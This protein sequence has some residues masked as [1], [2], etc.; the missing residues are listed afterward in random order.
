MGCFAST[1]RSS[2]FTIQRGSRVQGAEKVLYDK[3][4][5][6]DTALEVSGLVA[7]FHDG[8]ELEQENIAHGRRAYSC[9]YWGSKDADR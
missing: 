1:A 4:E 6:K 9:N 8:V 7:L 3:I 2:P 5:G